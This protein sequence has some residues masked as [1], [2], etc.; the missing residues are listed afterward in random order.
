MIKKTIKNE[1]I[2]KV[3]SLLNK[4][5]KKHPT[6]IAILG[7]GSH[8]DM[9]RSLG[10]SCVNYLLF[11]KCSICIESCWQEIEWYSGSYVEPKTKYNGFFGIDPHDE[12][13]IEGIA[14]VI[15]KGLYDEDDISKFIDVAR[16]I[17]AIMSEIFNR[18][19]T[20]KL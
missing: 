19:E 2:R 4:N 10:A 14:S 12:E 13:N 16:Q 11:G 6:P 20:S 3:G 17:P 5:F 18:F 7:E 15:A 8:L 1:M 9:M